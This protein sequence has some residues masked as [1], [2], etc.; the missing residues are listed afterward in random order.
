MPASR[1]TDPVTRPGD[2]E[3]R[4]VR[5][6]KRRKTVSAR[7]VGG[8]LE[9]AIPAWMSKA[10][11]RRWVDEMRRRFERR[12]AGA[13][14]DLESRVQALAARYAL[15]VPDTVRFVDNQESRW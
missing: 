12:S 11:E 6:A 5:S 4:V 10:E 9:V 15:P 13:A 3:V 7:L 1:P 2:E 14:I 8:V